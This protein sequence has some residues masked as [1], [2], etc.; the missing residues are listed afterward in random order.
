MYVVIAALAFLGW[1]TIA[2]V[3]RSS[4]IT[5]KQADYVTAA[6]AL[7]AGTTPDPAPAASCR[8][9][10]LHGA[11]AFGRDVPEHDPDGARTKRL[12]RRARSRTP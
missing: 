11:I 4:V 5:A 6:R 3:M 10:W 7:G 1:T 8:T 9:A 2:R 12:R